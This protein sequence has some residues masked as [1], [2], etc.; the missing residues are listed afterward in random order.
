MM[1]LRSASVRVH[2]PDGGTLGHRQADS[3]GWRQLM[4]AYQSTVL[5]MAMIARRMASV[6]V[7]HAASSWASSVSSAGK[8][9][10]LVVPLPCK[11]AFLL[12][13]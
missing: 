9:V 11:N 7:G 8:V 13:F 10:P 2:R 5:T 3:G 1:A 4:L 6:R 12:A